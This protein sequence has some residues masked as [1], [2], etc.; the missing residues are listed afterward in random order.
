MTKQRLRGNDEAA[1]GRERRSSACAG[2]TGH[3][4][5]CGRFQFGMLACRARATVSAP[6]SVFLFTT[7]PAPTVPPLATVTGATS[8]QLLPTCTS[9]SITVRLLFAPS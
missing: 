7:E 9:A 3:F 4:F 2:T 8:T 5:F 6:G 1:P